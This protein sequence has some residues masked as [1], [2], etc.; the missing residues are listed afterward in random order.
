MSNL[1]YFSYDKI[2]SYNARFNMVLGPRGDGKTYGAKKKAI[3]DF[4]TRGDQFI[5]LR[6]YREETLLTAQT[7]FADIEDEFP[8]W[9]FKSGGIA[10]YIAPAETRGE[11]KRE[12]EII[13]Y[14]L[15]LSRAQSYKGVSFHKVKTI[16][17]DEFIIEKSAQRYLPNEVT[18]FLNFYSTIDRN[19]EKTRVFMLANAIGIANP[20]FIYYKIDPNNANA[21]GFLKVRDK[22]M[23][24][25]ID[26]EEFVRGVN[27]TWF[28]NLINGT[29]YGDYATRNEF[30]DNNDAM[31][32][33]KNPNASYIFTLETE[34]G[35]FSIWLD[36]KTGRYHAQA[37]RPGNEKIYTLVVSKMEEGKTL[38]TFNDK[39]LGRLR[40]S[41][42]HARMTFDRAST[43]N[44]FLEI[45][46]R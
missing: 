14:A 20:Y 26:D 25:F 2:L 30:K 23:V 39:P 12:W 36:M 46:K 4:L 41:F 37:D 32:A 29:E 15:S 42:R 11:K 21:Q 31:L 17:F 13:G 43:R 40:T 16:I 24:Q 44:A 19:L 9:D 18:I 22:F 33:A 45:F 38:V 35:T 3:K 6:R 34:S 1:K 10:L 8:D 27:E 7:F 5:I 28:G